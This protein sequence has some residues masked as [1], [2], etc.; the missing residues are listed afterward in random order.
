MTDETDP[1]MEKLPDGSIIIGPESVRAQLKKQ[2]ADAIANAQTVVASINEVTEKTTNE[3][4]IEGDA[5]SP[6]TLESK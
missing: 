5:S 1:G 3:T 4:Y 6:G 2:A